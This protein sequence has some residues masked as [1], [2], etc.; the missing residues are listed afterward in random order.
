MRYLIRKMVKLTGTLLLFTILTFSVYA[1]AAE[2]LADCDNSSSNLYVCDGGLS[3]KDDVQL[4]ENGTVRIEVNGALKISKEVE[5]NESGSA[6][7]H[8]TVTGKVTIQKDAEINANIKADE[9]VDIK[10]DVEFNGNIESD[11]EIKV[12]K[13]V[14]INGNI[15]AKGDVKLGKDTEVN[16]YVNAPNYDDLGSGTVNGETCDQNDNEGAC[17]GTGNGT[18][19]NIVGDWHF[20]EQQWQGSE[21][22]V[23]DSSGN[24]YDGEALRDARTKGF[25]SAIPGAIGTCRYGSFNGANQVQIPRISALSSSNSVSVSLWFKGGSQ[26]QDPNDNDEDYQTLLILGEGPTL[27]SNGR[28]EV[29][30]RTNGGGLNFEVRNNQGDVYSAE[31]GDQRENE[32]QL[33]N[34]EWQ[35]LAGTFDADEGQLRLYIN[36]TEVATLS[37]PANFNLNNIGGQPNLY[38]GGQQFG[39][40]G[41]VGEI[42]EVT[43]ATGVYTPAE[44]TQL[45]NRARNCDASQVLAQCSAVWPTAFDDS[46]NT[47]PQAFE[48]PDNS[49][50]NQLPQQLQPVDYL[51][52]GDF[53]DVGENYDTNGETSRVY[54]DGDLT[55]QSGR[56]IN[57]SGDPSE[58]IFIVTGDLTIERNVRING[59]VYVQGNLRYYHANDIDNRWFRNV[60]NRR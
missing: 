1:G 37:T 30:R 35:H 15:N 3:L 27:G 52:V 58:L 8:I 21:N 16:G 29:Y 33:F 55:I 53:A 28:F 18:Q 2:S 59:Y 42:D 43:V 23:V 5:F 19:S 24:D 40:N 14:E 51:R 22:E 54:I 13:N 41:V 44:I 32:P 60:C 17:G 26:R 38:I 47:Q 34:D 31:Y 45:Y 39:T 49:S 25:F 20:D 48:L 57:T 6:T 56:R 7:V 4:S 10:K 36:G 46:G 9:K 11:D 50:Q 12:D